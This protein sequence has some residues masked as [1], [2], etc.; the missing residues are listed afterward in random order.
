[1]RSQASISVV[2]PTYNCAA[3]LAR[4]LATVREWLDLVHE[5]V[6]VDSRSSD[7]TMALI[8]DGL[9]HPRLRLIERDRGLY[10]SWNEG[11]AA[12]TGDWVYISTAGDTITRE[13]LLHLC[14]VG[15]RLQADVVVS[16]PCFV[17]EDGRSHRDLGWPPAKLLREFGKGA[18]FVMHPAITQYLA[19][20]HC[21]S[22]L[23]GSSASNLYR[24][25]HLRKR[26]F[27]TEYGPVG[28]TAWIMR[29]AHE[30]RLALTPRVGSCFCIHEKEHQPTPDQCYALYR[31]IFEGELARLTRPVGLARTPIDRYLADLELPNRVERLRLQKRRL[32]RNHQN[33]LTSKVRW[34]GATVGYL[35]WRSKLKRQRRMTM[36]ELKA[37]SGWFLHLTV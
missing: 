34:L 26:P 14:D 4:H 24:G 31:K 10:Q 21:P 22:A 8:R 18:P 28:D 13:Q 11:I 15:E 19:F 20:L 16:P 29:Y 9:Q 17:H 7:G 5:V 6:V 33:R 23:L 30:T 2:L 3:L 1:M 12:T 35:W 36:G 32:W 37:E 25:A 27:P